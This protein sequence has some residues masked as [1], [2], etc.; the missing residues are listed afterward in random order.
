MKNFKPLSTLKQKLSDFFQQHGESLGERFKTWLIICAVLAILITSLTIIRRL[1]VPF[2]LEW[3]ESAHL[4]VAKRILEG[5]PLYTIPSF[6]Y[7]PFLYAPVFFYVSALAVAMLGASLTTIR[8]VSIIFCVLTA[9]LIYKTIKRETKQV[10]WAIIGVGLYAACYAIT[11]GSYDLPKVDT[12]F[13]YLVLL[14]AYLLRYQ[15]SKKSRLLVG[16]IFTLAFLTKQSALFIIAP[17]IIYD[18]LLQPKRG[19]VLALTTGLTL[20]IT[21]FIMDKAS[22]GWSTYYLFE[23]TSKAANSQEWVKFGTLWEDY[24]AKVGGLIILAVVFWI[25]CIKKVTVYESWFV[26]SL[27]AVFLSWVGRA[28]GFYNVLVPGYL[29]LCLVACLA[30]GSN[31]QASKAQKSLVNLI[32]IGQFL[33]LFVWSVKL[34]FANLLPQANQKQAVLALHSI[35]SQT[36]GEVY[37]PFLGAPPP[38]VH[39]TAY[40]HIGAVQDIFIT[41]SIY[42][43]KLLDEFNHAIE[44][45]YFAL[46]AMPC[47]TQKTRVDIMTNLDEYY[48]KIDSEF[49]ENVFIAMPPTCLYVPKGQ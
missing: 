6:E 21:L 18:F 34:P 10:E 28:S 12:L 16:V 35:I 27:S 37:I 49:E 24:A 39:K 31:T 9:V 11:F 42:A 19:L 46:I 20:A 26:F 23:I 38:F 44:E 40:P 43:P 2:D 29:A 4:A 25:G 13:V 48:V 5:K 36:Q 41:Y 30:A 47:D 3:Q 33:L 8:L 15:T 22:G 7:V 17:L 32:L 45:Q 1:F 14:G